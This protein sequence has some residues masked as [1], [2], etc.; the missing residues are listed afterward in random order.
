MNKH[1]TPI[2]GPECPPSFTR[3]AVHN[4]EQWLALRTKDVTA[5]VAGALLGVH[6]YVTPYGLWALKSGKIAEDPEESGAMRR[7]RMLEPVAAEMLKEAY[8]DWTIERPAAYFRDPAARLGAT[9]DLFCENDRGW[10][11]VQ[12]KTVEPG[13]FRKKW[14]DQDGELQ[15]P[16]WIAAQ[17]IVEAHLTGCEW[18]ACAALVVGFGIDLHVVP[19]PVHAALIARI[20]SEVADFWKKV[21]SGE[22]PA[23]DYGRD[24]AVIAQLY[25][26]ADE[27]V[28]D[29]TGDNRMPELL[30][31]DEAQ[32]EIEKNAKA[33]RSAIKAE[34]IAKMGNAGFATVQGWRVSA[35]TINRKGYSVEASSYRQVRANR[36]EA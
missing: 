3:H 17:A 9:P 35:K 6:D 28:L 26:R 5:S 23:M 29:L 25:G 34:I 11:V 18:A 1:V 16:L 30:S 10:G 4:R 33:K 13:I 31:E 21:E 19:V 14:H 22:E 7:G 20:K 24:G 12:V 36:L 15:P 2:I 27:T 32:A 8:P